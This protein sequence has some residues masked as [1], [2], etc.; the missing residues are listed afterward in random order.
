MCLQIVNKTGQEKE[1][2]ILSSLKEFI[3][4]L[5]K[6]QAKDLISNTVCVSQPKHDKTSTRY[7][8]LS[9]STSGCFPGRIIVAASCLSNWEEYVAW[10]VMTYYPK[11]KK[12]YFDGTFKL[13]EH[14]RC[15][16]FNLST[17]NP[18]LPCTSCA[19]LFGFTEKDVKSWPYGNCAED[20]S[21]S[22]L[23]K[24]E[25]EVKNQAR[26][27]SPSYTEDNKRQ[28]K[29]SVMKEL[30]IYLA[31]IKF[32]WDKTFYTPSYTVQEDK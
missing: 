22:N 6:D 11:T 1:N 17:L 2:E 24:H 8:G 18:M 7:Y 10:A 32:S 23:L 21:I 16:A 9:M 12:P 19:N 25:K 15:A 5:K 4:E 3:A 30:T 20:E 13:P 29:E 31:Q 14:V 26:P 28:A 27:S